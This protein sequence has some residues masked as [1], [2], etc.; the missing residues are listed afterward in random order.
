L[1]ESS[2]AWQLGQDNVWVAQKKSRRELQKDTASARQG[3]NC[4]HS[5]KPQKQKQKPK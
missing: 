5:A 3:F 4:H 2:R 1:N